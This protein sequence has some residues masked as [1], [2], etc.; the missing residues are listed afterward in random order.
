MSVLVL[1]IVGTVT[2]STA[3]A[4]AD[5]RE[6]VVSVACHTS[7]D[8][9]PSASVVLSTTQA[10]G[11]PVQFVRVPDVGVPSTG[12]IRACPLGNTTVPVKVGEAR[13]ALSARSVSSARVQFLF[14]RV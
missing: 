4:P 13:F 9:T 6:I 3:I 7:R 10:S 14:C 12:A 1:L 2:P 5:T 8:H 11:S